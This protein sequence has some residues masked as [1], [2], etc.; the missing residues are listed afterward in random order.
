MKKTRKDKRDGTETTEDRKT[1]MPDD[2]K[3]PRNLGWKNMGHMAK[4]SCNQTLESAEPD[5][6]QIAAGNRGKKVFVT[7][8]GNGTYTVSVCQKKQRGPSRKGKGGKK[9]SAEDLSEMKT[10]FRTKLSE[11]KEEMKDEL[12]KKKKEAKG[13]LR[14]KMKEKLKR[15]KKDTDGWDGTTFNKDKTD[16]GTSETDAEI[17][18]NTDAGTADTGYGQPSK[19][20]YSAELGGFKT[21]GTEGQGDDPAGLREEGDATCGERVILLSITATDDTS[22]A[23]TTE[24]RRLLQDAATSSLTMEVGNYQFV[25][26]AVETTFEAEVDAEIAAEE[27]GET[28][29]ASYIKNALMLISFASLFLISA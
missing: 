8:N 12:K 13:K 7:N 29:G 18:T 22:V 26:D 9:I 24:T 5:T 10:K 11:A 2:D 15:R 4:K 17:N 27:E 23:A 6:V 20:I 14:D 19:G 16:W 3:P 21:F 1:T 28:S 25:D